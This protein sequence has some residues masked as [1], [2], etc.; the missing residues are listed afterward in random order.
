VQLAYYATIIAAEAIGPSGSTS[1]TEI[2]VDDLQVSGYAFYEGGV[3]FR[4]AIIN[5]AAFFSGET[6]RTST[7][8]GLTLTGPGIVPS[9]MTIKRLQRYV[10]KYSDRRLSSIDYIYIV[11][12][13]TTRLDGHEVGR[14]TRLLMQPL[15]DIECNNS[16]CQCWI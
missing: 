15:G 13:Q 7:H 8:I 12:M 5:F 11:G 14:H 2:V 1:A 9:M 3:L 6:N 10:S 4:A 16:T